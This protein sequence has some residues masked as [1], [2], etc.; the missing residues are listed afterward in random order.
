MS[1]KMHNQHAFSSGVLY[2]GHVWND[3][4]FHNRKSYLNLKTHN[5][6]PEMLLYDQQFENDSDLNDNYKILSYFHKN[7]QFF[8]K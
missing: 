2:R 6:L 7:V 4:L 3:V 5:I 8:T 1:P